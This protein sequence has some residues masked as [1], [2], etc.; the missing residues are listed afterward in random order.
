V[1]VKN[2]IDSFSALELLIPTPPLIWS[3]KK[4]GPKKFSVLKWHFPMDGNFRCGIAPSDY[5]NFRNL[6]FAP[7]AFS[8]TLT[9]FVSRVALTNNVNSTSPANH[10]AVGMAIF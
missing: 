2:G 5:G 10:L 4:R 1:H 7:L 3:A 6:A 9:H 8:T